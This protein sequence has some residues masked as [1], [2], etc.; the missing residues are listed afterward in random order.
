[1]AHWSRWLTSR[2]FD[3]RELSMTEVDRFL[4]A[5]RRAG[6]TQYLSANAMAPMLA[7]LRAQG[8]VVMPFPQTPQGPV[9]VALARYRQYLCRN[10]DS[11]ARPLAG[12]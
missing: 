2:G 7:S 11:D 9:D 1:M 6:Y 12:M 8:V 5:R 4:T 3:L 10:A